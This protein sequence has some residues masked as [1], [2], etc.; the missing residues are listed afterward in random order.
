MHVIV[1]GNYPCVKTGAPC[2]PQKRCAADDLTQFPTKDTGMEKATLGVTCCDAK[3][4]GTRPGCFKDATFAQAID[5]CASNGLE[6]CSAEQIVKGAGE[7]TGCKFDHGMVWTIDACDGSDNTEAPI[8][9]EEPTTTTT[10]GEPKTT[11]TTEAPTEP[12]APEC[13]GSWTQWLNRDLPTASGDWETTADF[14]KEQP[15]RMCQGTASGIQARVRATKQA[16]QEGVTDR[17]FKFYSAEKG[18]VCVNKEGALDGSR[19]KDYEVRFC[20]DQPITSTTTTTTTEE[21]TTTT[22]TTTTEAPVTTSTSTTTAAPAGARWVKDASH[23]GQVAD[24]PGVDVKGPAADTNGNYKYSTLSNCKALCEKTETCNFLSRYVDV[25]RGDQ[26]AWHCYFHACPDPAQVTWLKQNRWGNGKQ[27]AVAY[28]L[29]DR[30]ND[31]PTTTTTEEPTT[32][33]T[34]TTTE[35]P[36]TTT[37]EEPTTTTSS[38]TSSTTTTEEPTTTTTTTTTVGPDE[39]ASS[40]SVSV[41]DAQDTTLSPDFSQLTV[42]VTEGETRLTLSSFNAWGEQATYC[43]LYGEGEDRFFVSLPAT[44]TAAAKLTQD[45]GADGHFETILNAALPVEAEAKASKTVAL[46]HSEAFDGCRVRDVWCY[47]MASKDKVGPI[48]LQATG[49]VGRTEQPKPNQP[50]TITASISAVW[51]GVTESLTEKVKPVVEE[52]A[53]TFQVEVASK[54][55]KV[56]E[57]VSVRSATSS[58]RSRLGL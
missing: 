47:S 43:Y 34:T 49:C 30:L 57:V 8:S 51:N 24:C 45:K 15:E 54:V 5:H 13:A 9:T 21:P 23:K 18:F 14:A 1:S 10:T 28:Y 48:S 36:T 6:L 26:D 38:T 29:P 41:A 27:N 37:T 42:Q 33:T 32:S 7:A 4:R 58:L 39:P 11:T 53:Q 25:G 31:W 56:Q 16:A 19:C 50:T 17:Q 40:V 44:A 20:C 22:T 2:N 3:G 46:P 55:E 35:E 52:V 12:A